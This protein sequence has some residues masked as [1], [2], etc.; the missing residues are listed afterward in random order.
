MLQKT[1][2][3]SEIRSGSK[4]V[5]DCSG[6]QIK[7]SRFVFRQTDLSLADFRLRPT[8][9]GALQLEACYISQVLIGHG[10]RIVVMVSEAL[11][12]SIISIDTR[13]SE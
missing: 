3:N 5:A 9:K 11:C 4:V 12:F 6:F 7:E 10:Y 13:T 2:S 1:L 8:V